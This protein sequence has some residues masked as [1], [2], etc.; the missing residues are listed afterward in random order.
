MGDTH[1]DALVFFGATGDL[2]YKKIFPALQAMAK[3]GHLNVPVIGVAKAGWTLDQLRARAQESVEKYG[4]LDRPAFDKLCGLLRYV[5][6]DYRDPATFEALRRELGSA[7]HPAHYL[8]IPPTLFGSVVEQL[9][10]SGCAKGARVVVEKPFGQDLVSARNLNRILLGTFVERDIFRIDHYLGKRPVNNMLFVRFSNP[11][12]EAFWNRTL[13]ESV[14]ITMAEDFGVQGRGAFYDETGAIR[15]VVQ[16]HLF[17]VLSNLA[18]EPPARMDSESLRDERVK[19]LKSIPPLEADDVIRGQ[20]RGYRQERGVAVDSQV[21]TYAAVRLR[22]DSW[23]WQGVPFYIRTGK[24]LPVTST[25]VVMRLRRPPT[26]FLFP[27][28]RPLSNYFRF[29]IIPRVT[30]AF[31]LTAMDEADQM[32]GQPAELVA[33]RRPGS[34]ERAAY[35]RVLSD[36]LEGDPSLFARMDYVEEAWRIVDPVRTMNTPVR[37]YEPGTWGPADRPQDFAP[38]GGWA[39]STTEEGA[40]SYA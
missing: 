32:I 38:Q 14:Q 12:M 40:S 13:V 17:Q 16:N 18:M 24:C 4:G 25:E 31:G 22:I 37:E 2:A 26:G 11:V 36:A 6:G 10:R 21:E 35:E 15:D 28:A 5:D 19:V 8:A 20:F 7:E 34:D 27:D 1:S 29:R 23:R 30:V 39:N 3:R 9:A 33:S